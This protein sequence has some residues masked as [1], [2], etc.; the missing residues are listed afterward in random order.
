MRRNGRT[1]LGGLGR[2][3]VER[4]ATEVGLDRIVASEIE[5]SNLLTN[6]V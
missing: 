4:L 2:A 5:V 6:M 1:T 3:I